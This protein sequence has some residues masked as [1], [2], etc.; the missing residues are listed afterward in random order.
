MIISRPG[1]SS[2]RLL[3]ELI[4][5]NAMSFFP[6]IPYSYLTKIAETKNKIIGTWRAEENV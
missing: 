2:Y 1:L 6:K 4:F 3:V 5:L